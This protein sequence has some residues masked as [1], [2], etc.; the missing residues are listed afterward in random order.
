M[1]L[2]ARLGLLLTVECCN[3]ASYVG[4]ARR[5]EA[6]VLVCVFRR[7]PRHI[8]DLRSSGADRS[9]VDDRCRWQTA[10]ASL[11]PNEPVDRAR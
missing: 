4:Q 9:E 8:V 11:A 7:L 6:E 2:A 5:R 10:D 1:A 3:L